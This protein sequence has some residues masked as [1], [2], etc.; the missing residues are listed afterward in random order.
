MIKG[1]KDM[2][3]LIPTVSTPFELERLLFI[4]S[5]SSWYNSHI[6]NNKDIDKKLKKMRVKVRSG[7]FTKNSYFFINF[8]R[9]SSSIGVVRI[10]LC[11]NSVINIISYCKRK[12][13]NRQLYLNLFY[14]GNI[15]SRYTGSF[16]IIIFSD[17]S[18][19][20]TSTHAFVCH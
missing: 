16:K 15:Y 8:Y 1:G 3:L 6:S 2:L 9:S 17:V 11:I 13:Y 10:F 12:R 20:L 14:C 19:L 7:N 4:I 18:S 5:A